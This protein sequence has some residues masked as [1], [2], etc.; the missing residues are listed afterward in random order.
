MNRRVKTGIVMIAAALAIA[1]GVLGIRSLSHRSQYNLRLHLDSASGLC[2]R[3]P[4]MIQ[5]LKSGSVGEL[6]MVGDRPLAVLSFRKGIRVPVGSR[7]ELLRLGLFGERGIGIQLHDTNAYY[8]NGEDVTAERQPSDAH[9]S[10]PEA[11]GVTMGALGAA[12]SRE[13]ADKLDTVITLLRRQSAQLD[14]LQTVR[15]RESSHR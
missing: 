13:I 8:R 11:M 6:S 5:G 9:V 10:F 14:T 1:G 12:S 3:D 7:F 2:V 15:R 4:V